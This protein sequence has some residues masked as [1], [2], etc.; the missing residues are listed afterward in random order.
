M[1]AALDPL[2]DRRARVLGSLPDKAAAGWRAFLC[3]GI[4]YFLVAVLVPLFTLW[5]KGSLSGFSGKG[6]AYSTV[7]GVLG[8]LGAVC[9]IW[10]FQNGGTPIRVMPLVF[11]GAPVVTAIINLAKNP[12]GIGALDPRL[13][14]GLLL[15]SV[16]TWL[17]LSYAPH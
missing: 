3:V 8:A 5:S 15:A 7:G 2:R 13:L 11:A 6:V 16:G 14:I 17:V 1:D 12:E 10:A 4:A 9:I